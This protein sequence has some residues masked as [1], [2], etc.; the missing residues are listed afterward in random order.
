MEIIDNIN[1][2]LGNNLKQTLT[3]GSI[4]LNGDGVERDIETGINYLREAARLGD[5]VA[6]MEL[7]NLKIKFGIETPET[8]TVQ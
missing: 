1:N 8:P 7:V 2:L 3:L 4:F 5:D 6:K